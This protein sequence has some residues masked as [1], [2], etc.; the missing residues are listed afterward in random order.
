MIEDPKES[1]W[2]ADATLQYDGL[3]VCFPHS[4]FFNMEVMGYIEKYSP[5]VVIIFSTVPVG[6]T[7]FLAACSSSF[8]RKKSRRIKEFAHF[9]VEGKHPDIAN[10]VANYKNVLG[11]AGKADKIID[12]ISLLFYPCTILEN[13]DQSEFLKLRSLAYYAIN[14]EFARA[15]AAWAKEVG[16]DYEMLKVYDMEYNEFNV[17][18]NRPHFTRYVLDPPVG[19]IGGHCVLAGV[20]HL[21]K[22]FPDDKILD[23]IDDINI[24]LE[25]E[26]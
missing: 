21:L 19:P 10:D 2:K 20:R 25:A 14:I 18:M 3:L 26:R 4:A 9:P 5:D 23:L 24:G 17:E 1:S 22:A 12:I 8:D 15:S 11:P 7:K 16:I 6:T 13:S